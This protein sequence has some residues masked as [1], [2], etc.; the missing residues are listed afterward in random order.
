MVTNYASIEHLSFRCF[1][2][3]FYWLPIFIHSIY[4]FVLINV[5]FAG[6]NLSLERRIFNYRLSR[7]RRISE[8][9]FGILSARWRILSRPIECK[10]DN[11]DNIVKATIALHNYLRRSDD[12]SDSNFKYV[13]PSFLEEWR[14]IV[15]GDTNMLRVPRLGSNMS[16]ENARQVREEF[17]AYFHYA[18]W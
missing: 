13:S 9:A 1:Y 7:A 8:N 6:T 4:L 10:P 3:L 11:V 5:F 17:C 16:S 15:E 12:A 18:T 14:S 2:C